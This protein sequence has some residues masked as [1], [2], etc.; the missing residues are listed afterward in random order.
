[1]SIEIRNH[2][3][4]DASMTTTTL[5]PSELISQTLQVLH[6]P[7]ADLD[8]FVRQCW[9]LSTTFGESAETRRTAVECLRE[10]ERSVPGAPLEALVQKLE[11][12]IVEHERSTALGSYLALY[13]EILRDVYGEKAKGNREDGDRNLGILRIKNGEERS[14]KMDSN[15][16]K[17]TRYFGISR[18][19]H[20]AVMDVNGEDGKRIN[21]AVSLTVE[22]VPLLSKWLKI[23]TLGLALQLVELVGGSVN[24]E[25]AQGEIL[26]AKIVGLLGNRT[27][28]LPA[29]FMMNLIDNDIQDETL[30]QNI[31]RATQNIANDTRLPVE[32]R[33]AIFEKRSVFMFDPKACAPTPVDDLETARVSALACISNFALLCLKKGDAS[34]ESTFDVIT[35]VSF[36]EDFWREKKPPGP[37]TKA[38]FQLYGS[39]VAKFSH[40]STIM[41]RLADLL[42]RGCVLRGGSKFCPSLL[43]F[44]E[45]VEEKDVRLMFLGRIADSL[46]DVFNVADMAGFFPLLQQSLLNAR[47]DLTRGLS[48]LER[49]AFYLDFESVDRAV[50]W[51]AN[52][53]FLQC[54]RA[55]LV[56]RDEE[57]FFPLLK[58]VRMAQLRN[59]NDPIFQDECTR[60]NHVVECLQKG[61]TPAKKLLC[62]KFESSKTTLAG[63]IRAAEEEETLLQPVDPDGE[64]D[65]LFPFHEHF[66]IRKVASETIFDVDKD[67]WLVAFNIS[68]VPVAKQRT[69]YF[70]FNVFVRPPST[71][72]VS[73]CF[74]P[75]NAVTLPLVCSHARDDF[76]YDFRLT[77]Q[78]RYPTCTNLTLFAEGTSDDGLH[79]TGPLGYISVV[80]ADFFFFTMPLPRS[81]VDA[82]TSSFVVVSSVSLESVANFVQSLPK[83]FVNIKKSGG[84]NAAWDLDLAILPR[85]RLMLGLKHDAATH[86]LLCSVSTNYWP[87]LAE[88]DGFLSFLGVNLHARE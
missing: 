48:A 51:I 68:L 60:L 78:P 23:H 76:Q 83:Q 82:L 33:S 71:T 19:V 9:S 39:I 40:S 67:A 61:M 56:C 86:T 7:Q 43:E 75:G 47:W 1:M 57:Y 72:T 70:A 59:V 30:V 38:A 32:V 28:S 24:G 10:I 74:A 42:I 81:I 21:R 58:I 35:L 54:I 88:I 73:T 55:A 80:L 31:D 44:L 12:V 41:D 46:V 69:S 52:A 37:L 53:D 8:S 5:S 18:N 22:V 17:G 13:L 36:V 85:H 11:T 2:S 65:D 87:L 4:G 64:N 15:R 77:L 66:K 49:F 14:K 79:L 34:L 6:P 84:Q 25:I 29:V 63:V 27:G 3:I 62:T 26:K 20:G 16:E 45:G 50:A